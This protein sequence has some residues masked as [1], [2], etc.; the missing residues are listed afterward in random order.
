MRQ[1]GTNQ[2]KRRL[3]WNNAPA[4]RETTAAGE[5]ALARLVLDFCGSAAR[6]AAS[7]AG[8]SQGPLCSSQ[9]TDIPRKRPTTIS[10]LHVAMGQ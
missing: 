6:A 10:A 4:V 9:G 7:T 5:A 2:R 8:P 1:G 3:N